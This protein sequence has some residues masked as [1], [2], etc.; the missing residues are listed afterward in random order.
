MTT[1]E[2]S[3]RLTRWIEQNFEAGTAEPV[4]AA[5]RELPLQTQGSQSIERI[6]AALV[7]R[8]QGEWCRFQ[9]M[10]ALVDTDWRDALVAADLADAD[11]PMRLDAVLGR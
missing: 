4:L 5:L 9:E 1:V 8:S 2:V 7:I 10:L 6:Q 11:W 3:P